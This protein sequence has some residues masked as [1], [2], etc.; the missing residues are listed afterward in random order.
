MSD[1]N[2]IAALAQLLSDSYVKPVINPR[3]FAPSAGY[4]WDSLGQVLQ[5]P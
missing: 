3:R 4:T 5:F 1:Q 2:T